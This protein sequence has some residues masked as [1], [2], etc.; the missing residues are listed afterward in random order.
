MEKAKIIIDVT[1]DGVK[2]HMSVDSDLSQEQ[3]I[4][5]LEH[6]INLLR[7]GEKSCN[8][9]ADNYPSLTS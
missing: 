8:T 6:L 3:T 5:A 4:L 2:L 1:D 9:L 7:I